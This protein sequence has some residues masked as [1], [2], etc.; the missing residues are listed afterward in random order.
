MASVDP[1]NPNQDI[2]VSQPPT[3]SVS[4]MAWSP[5]ANIL[6]AGS[7]DKQLRCWEVS[8]QNG[9]TQPKVWL[10]AFFSLFF[11]S[12]FAYL[13]QYILA[14]SLLT[15]FTVFSCFLLLLSW[16]AMFAHDAPVLSCAFSTDGSRVF[17]GSC[18][19]KGKMWDLATQQSQQVAEHA[20]PIKYVSSLSFV[21]WFF[22]FCCHSL[23]LSSSCFVFFSHLPLF[24]IFLQVHEIYCR[25]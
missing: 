12:F 14:R 4:C 24:L 3:D 8:T 19:K 18:D 21:C 25:E 9:Q 13:V 16:Q 7:W 11:L 20:A 2:M 5:T 17:T 1:S 22:F 23:S 6:V 15:F 10:S